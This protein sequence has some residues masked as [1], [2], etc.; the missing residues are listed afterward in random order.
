ME[1]ECG[2]CWIWV[3]DGV[4]GQWMI[5]MSGSDAFIQELIEEAL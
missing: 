2:E 4:N 5:G 3:P 1:T